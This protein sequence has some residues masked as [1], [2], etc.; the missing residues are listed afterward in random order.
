MSANFVG[1]TTMLDCPDP[2]ALAEF[3]AKV[4]DSQVYPQMSMKNGVPHWVAIADQNEKAILV[5]QRV[6]NYKAPTWPEGPIPQQMHLDIDV[7]D[8]DAAEAV[9]LANGGKK[10][11]FQP[12]GDAPNAYRVFFDPVGHVFCLCYAG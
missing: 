5:F 3:Y 6:E 12:G 9:V 8:L 2:V 10:A 1:V 7:R 4:T 11:E